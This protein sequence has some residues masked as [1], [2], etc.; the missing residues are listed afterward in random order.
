MILHDLEDLRREAYVRA[1][2]RAAESD[3][4]VGYVGRGV[5]VEIFH[6]MDLTPYPIY[7]IDGDILKYSIE[8]NLCPLIDATVTYAK[9]DK[10]PLIHSSK[11]IVIGDT[12][13]TMAK[14]LAKVKDV[15]VYD[16]DESLI[17][18]LREVYDCRDFQNDVAA[19]IRERLKRVS[20]F[21][22]SFELP[23]L[24]SFIIEYFLNFLDIDERMNFL[25]GLSSDELKSFSD[26]HEFVSLIY[27]CATCKKF[28]IPH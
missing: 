7:G 5:P 18:K 11:L 16:D 4:V 10:C 22:K 17:V 25:G 27:G 26:V 15:Y 8:E 6:A 9:T 14:E 3:S 20:D 28:L 19:S 12:C 23:A 13:S 21:V 1:V 24:Q 2:I